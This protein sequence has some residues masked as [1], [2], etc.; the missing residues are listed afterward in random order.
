M[1]KRFAIVTKMS[2]EMDNEMIDRLMREFITTGAQDYAKV[3]FPDKGFAGIDAITVRGP[4]PIFDAE[5]ALIEDRADWVAE[6]NVR[7]DR[8]QQHGVR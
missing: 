8:I 2:T 6:G 3:D 4:Y 5:G 7:L 1:I